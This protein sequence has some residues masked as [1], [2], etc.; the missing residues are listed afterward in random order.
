MRDFADRWSFHSAL[1]RL[2]RYGGATPI[3]SQVGSADVGGNTWEIWN[4]M[5]GDMEVYSFVASSPVT[6]FNADIKE[7]WDYLTENHSYPADSQYLLSKFHITT[8][9]KVIVVQKNAF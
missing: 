9:L 7:F 2:G 3:G 5:N 4:G 1:I 8:S 6:S